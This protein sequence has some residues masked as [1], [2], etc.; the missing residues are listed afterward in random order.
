M[1]PLL[2]LAFFLSGASGL[3]YQ[4][5]WVRMLT[6]YL[7]ATTHAT[8]TVLVVFM[9]GLA[10]GSFLAARFADR[11]R[12]PL[13]LYCWLEL[14]IGALGLLASFAVIKGVGEFYVRMYDLIGE[15]PGILLA[16]RVVFAVVC[17]LPPTILMGATL[18]LMVTFVTR[19]GEHFQAGLGRLYALNTFGAVAG[20]LVTGLYLLGEFGERVTLGIAAGLNVIA[21]AI[22]LTLARRQKTVTSRATTVPPDPAESADSIEPYRASIRRLALVTLFVSG[23]TA[24]TY[25]I[26]WTRLLVLVLGTSIYAFSIML[27]V[28]LIGI[29]WGSLGASH[30]SQKGHDP[31]SKYGLLQVINGL[32]AALGLFVLPFLHDYW[33]QVNS[34]PWAM[35][36]SSL[37]VGILTCVFMV[38][39]VAYCF[40]RQF[41]LGVRCCIDDPRFPGRSTGRAYAVNTVGTILGALL[42]G[43][44]VLPVFGTTTPILFLGGVAILLGWLSLRLVPKPERGRRSLAAA[45][46]SAVFALVVVM[47]EIQLGGNCYRHAM[48]ARVH[49]QLGEGIQIYAWHEGSAASTVAAG[50]PTDQHTRSLMVNGHGMTVL[51]S[52]T[53]IMAHLPYYL[54]ERPKRMLVIC[55]GM[56]TT[57]RSATGYADLHVDAVELVPEVFDCFRFYHSDW[58]EVLRRPNGHRHVDDGR[59]YLLKHRELYDVITIDPAPPLYSAGSVNLYTHEFFSLCKSRLT[60]GGV[61]CM[62]LPPAPKRELLMIM[63]SFREVFEEGTLWQGLDIAGFYLIG[64]RRSIK[65]TSGQVAALAEA[66]SRIP[67]MLEWNAPVYGNTENLRQL[68]LLDSAALAKLVEGVPAVTDDMPYTEFPLWRQINDPA[69]R[70]EFKATEI[71]NPSS[72]FGEPK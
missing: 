43:F 10:L 16:A 19:V 61:M 24:L 17:L 22:A 3:I 27:A 7:G 49:Y 58:E 5:V 29:A 59:N 30:D 66:L 32:W 12:R 31:L 64:G 4:T 15:R 54:A 41:P 68:Y 63:K 18:P 14:A 1:K 44:F 40:G 34:D 65:Q 20:V 13:A 51:C 36:G 71:P 25:E 46:L 6:R 47:I 57:F 37:I 38:L 28:F 39:P 67:D 33:L 62:W 26:L 52:E 48:I 60:P 42:A 70:N 11:L 53:K 23:L 56:G 9:A 45:S 69:S 50:R 72:E 35:P 21:G 8:A 55:F 2:F